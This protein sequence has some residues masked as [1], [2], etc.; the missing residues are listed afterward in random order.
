VDAAYLSA[1]FTVCYRLTATNQSGGP[2]FSAEGTLEY[3][4]SQTSGSGHCSPP[5]I[6][7]LAQSLAQSPASFFTDGITGTAS[8]TVIND[9][10]SQITLDY[11]IITHDPDTGG[12]SSLMSLNGLPPGTPV[13]GTVTVPANSQ[14]EVPVGVGLDRSEPLLRDEILLMGDV[15]G[16]G[17]NETLASSIVRSAE[18]TTLIFVGVPSANTD[19]TARLSVSPNPFR[20]SAHILLVLPSSRQVEVSVFDIVGRRVRRLQHGVLEAGAHHL[21]WDGIDDSGHR[22]P[23]GLYFVSARGVTN[24]SLTTKFVQMP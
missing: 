6:G 15:A 20:G 11:Q 1:P 7:A 5:E 4:N 18:D 9:A 19:L 23:A 12:P 22:R 3:F 17:V 8:F 24:G 2:S 14:A 10:A 13:T 16:D 21:V